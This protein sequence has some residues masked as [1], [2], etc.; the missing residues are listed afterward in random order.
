MCGDI[1][2][3]TLWTCLQTNSERTVA[4]ALKH[5][6]ICPFFSLM[7]LLSDTNKN[8]G[9]FKIGFTQ[10]KICMCVCMISRSVI[11]YRRFR[12]SNLRGISKFQTAIHGNDC[13]S[14]NN[15]L[16]INPYPLYLAHLRGFLNIYFINDSEFGLSTMLGC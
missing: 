5:I 11:C 16:Q 4:L 6:E 2:Y 15:T 10:Y 12:C 14:K 13:V 8:K 3:V 1:F 9:S 7:R